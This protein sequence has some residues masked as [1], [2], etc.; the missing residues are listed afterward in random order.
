MDSGMKKLYQEA[1]ELYD[2]GKV[3]ESIKKLN[4]VIQAHPDYP[5]VHNAL[6]LAYSLAENREEAINSFKRAIELNP[7]YIEAYVHLAIIQNE[8]CHFEEAKKAFEKA[9]SLETKDKGLSPQLKAKLATTYSQLGDIYYELQEYTKA[10]DEYKRAIDVSS[11]FLDIRLK[12]AK[13]YIQLS[14]YADAEKLLRDILAQNQGYSEA[15]V[16]LGLCFY[17]QKRYGEA[18]QQWQETL[19]MD[20][21]NIKAKSYLNMLKEKIK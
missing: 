7:E 12:L 21:A 8:L 16:V 3:K 5:D 10:K 20:A 15:K 18:Q 19:E 11:T 6:G 13:T 14:G 17:Q 1:L 9:A 4:E 2:Q